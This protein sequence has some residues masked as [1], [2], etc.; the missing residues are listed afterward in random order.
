M[1]YYPEPPPTHRGIELA[2]PDAADDTYPVDQWKCAKCDTHVGWV[3]LHGT[4]DIDLTW[5]TT[6]EVDDQPCCEDCAYEP[7]EPCCDWCVYKQ[8]DPLLRGD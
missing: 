7:E 1:T 5:V 6:F 8:R 3:T 2:V 4:D